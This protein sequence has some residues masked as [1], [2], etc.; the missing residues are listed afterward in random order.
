MPLNLLPPPQPLPDASSSS[1]AVGSNEY[2]AG[3]TVVTLPLL[4]KI[5]L[6]RDCE[7]QSLDRG[8][9][10]SKRVRAV[11]ER[12]STFFTSVSSGGGG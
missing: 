6:L 2:P 9:R 12:K 1:A 4:P 7:R 10:K 11:I 8:E 5:L 3:T